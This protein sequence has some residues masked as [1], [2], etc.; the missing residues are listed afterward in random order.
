[1]HRV[2][3]AS[4]HIVLVETL[5]ATSL[6]RPITLRFC[7]DVACN[8][9]TSSNHVRFARQGIHINRKCVSHKHKPRRGFTGICFY[10]DVEHLRRSV[11]RRNRFLLI[12]NACG[13]C[14]VPAARILNVILFLPNFYACGISACPVRDL[15][16]YDYQGRNATM[17]RSTPNLEPYQETD[18]NIIRRLI[19]ILSG[20]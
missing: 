12:C 2:S 6:P 9:S 3:T 5:H 14:C 8:V 19:R 15:Q 11:W 10:V 13:V 1:M 16:H 17:K 7:R 18:K 4:N 20:D